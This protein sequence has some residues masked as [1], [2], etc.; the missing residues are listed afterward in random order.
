MPTLLMALIQNGA[1]IPSAAID[2]AAQRRS[3]GAA[4]V[5]ADAVERH[6]RS[7]V[8][9]RNELRDDRLPGRGRQRAADADQ[10]R[11]QQ[12]IARRRRAE[13]DDHGEDRGNCRDRD[14][15]P[16]SGTFAGRRCPRA[17]RPAARTGTSEGRGDLDQ[18]DDQ[19]VRI[20]ARSSA[21]RTPRCTST[22]D[23]GDDG[24]RPQHREG[25]VPERTP[26]GA[27]ARPCGRS[28]S[29][30]R[31]FHVRMISGCR[32]RATQHPAAPEGRS[33]GNYGIICVTADRTTG[34]QYR[35]MLP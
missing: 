10:K 21:S 7:E 13:P 17:R 4:D 27:A 23:V 26:G 28:T 33:R 16:R 1:A 20:E 29:F 9:P 35:S 11:E 15:R 6:R 18:R 34:L 19:R 32:A 30:A 25:R 22:A 12:E 8:L 14:L 3:D 5:D 2:H 24:R 31:R